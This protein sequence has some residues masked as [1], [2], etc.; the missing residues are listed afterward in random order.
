MKNLKPS[1]QIM[2]RDEIRGGLAIIEEAGR[3]CYKSERK[4][5][6]GSAE[7]FVQMC[8]RR[9][10]EAMLEHGDYIFLIEDKHIYD[11]VAESL[12]M[13]RDAGHPAPMLEMTCIHGRPIVSGNIRAWRDLFSYGSLAGAYFTGHID[14]LYTQCFFDSGADPDPRIRQI[15][16]ADLQ[17][18]LEK[19]THQR[20]SV[21]FIIDRGVSHEFVR[22]R[23]MSFAQESTRYCN[24]AGDR[25]E[26]EISAIVPSFLQH[27]DLALWRSSVISAETAYMHLL[28]SGHTPQEARSVLPTST[29]TELVMTGNLRAW[30]HFFDLRAKQLT[31]SAH[32]QAA[33]V[34]KP[35]YKLTKLMYDGVI[36]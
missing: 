14:G 22:H 18:R 15:R 8:I 12:Q 6:P 7:R 33:E 28:Q 9:R 29:K 11:N 23:T 16:Y 35:L 19:L 10:H 26:H 34:A 36:I 30:Q 4:I 3:T 32:P 1:F 13:I 24:Y 31:G 2:E 25:F 20:Q 27:E 5:E 21:R 17:D